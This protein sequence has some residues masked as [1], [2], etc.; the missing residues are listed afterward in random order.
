MF[1]QVQIPRPVGLGIPADA[2]D[3]PPGMRAGK[4]D[5]H[6]DIGGVRHVDLQIHAI[7]LRCNG[8]RVSVRR[9]MNEDSVRSTY[10]CYPVRLCQRINRRRL[11]TSCSQATPVASAAVVR[12]KSRRFMVLP[13][14][15][16]LGQ[17]EVISIVYILRR[18]R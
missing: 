16:P 18:D 6:G 2:S 1:E 14:S 5:Q 7:H 8:G 13:L 11:L 3:Q 17:A 12:R 15:G 4:F 9:A 10:D